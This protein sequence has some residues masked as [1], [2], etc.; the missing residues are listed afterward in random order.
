MKVQ[1]EV[2][3]TLATRS[4]TS[5]S[6]YSPET[7]QFCLRMQFHSTAAYN[8]LRTFFG[9]RLPTCRTL[10]KWLR[11]T[12]ASPG[13]TQPAI[14][15]LSHKVAECMASGKVLYLCVMTDDV[16]IRKHISYN[17]KTQEFEGFPTV[18]NS[19]SKKVLSAAKEALVFMVVG[20]NFK[21]P[22]AYFFSNGIQAI[23][24]AI[25][26]KEVLTAVQNTGAKIIS[27]TGDGLNSNITVA[28]ILGADFNA[29]K[30][31]FTLPNRPDERIH[32]IFD[33]PHMLKLV[34]R[35]L[36]SQLLYY[37]GDR[38][39]WNLLEILARKQDNDNFELGNKLS[40]DHINFNSAPMKVSLAVQT[41][42]NSVA[43]ALEQMCEDQ[44]EDFIDCE[45]TVE[46]IRLCNNVFDV[47]N[48]GDG[49]PSDEHFK[50]PIC[51]ANIER[52][53]TLF[54]EFEYFISSLKVD[55]Y[56]SKKHK[57][58]GKKPTRKPV[59]K[60]R[61]SV[62]FF[63]LL[64]N[65]RSI[66]NIYT[67]YIRSGLLDTFY[68]FQFSQD[69]LETYFSLIRSCLGWNNNPTEVQFKS[70]YRKLLVCMPHQ[71]ARNG[72]CIIN[73]TNVLTVSSAHQPTQQISK[74][75]LHQVEAIE[76]DIEEFDNLL[77]EEIE[78]YDQHIRAIVASTVEKN[79]VKR[80]S[81]RSVSGCQ[82]CLAVFSENQRVFDE[83]IAKKDRTKR[84]TQPCSSSVYIISA[85]NSV[86][87]LLQSHAHV[88][89]DVMAK[90]IFNNLDTDQLYD[91]SLFQNHQNYMTNNLTHKEQF[92]YDIIFEYLCLK[93][94]KIGKRITI[95]E[96]NGR[97]LRRKLTRNIILAGQ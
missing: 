91:S 97:A 2:L 67:D 61:S 43:D 90:T 81:L 4:S 53:R 14:D 29:N 94:K 21:L 52:F 30:P 17:E 11:C 60:S 75:P 68:T 73:S 36:A 62:G 33:P 85:C 39:K 93:S 22:V 64:N 45:S 34:R 8:E 88:N 59:L 96:Q 23:D 1:R 42:S 76:I 41:M 69:H 31:Y 50:Q 51:E 84:H 79:I 6:K 3:D 74:L 10:R 26:T 82:D 86:F 32:V 49:K 35:Y 25:L 18:T 77:H 9:K 46:F 28:K 24:R 54:Q 16:S 70:A 5:R 95:E 83:F 57:N 47:M 78:P 72:N 7:R 65:I 56:K 63:G 38:L 13:I 40:R 55:E 71:S 37:N 58:S 44:Y 87:K 48:Y 80:I 66:L 19:R 89:I 20:T 15:E 12:D 27:L 92:I